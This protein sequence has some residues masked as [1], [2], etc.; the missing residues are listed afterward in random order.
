MPAQSLDQ[1]EPVPGPQPA[2]DAIADMAAALHA[3]AFPSNR[4]MEQRAKI[5]DAA[6]E[7]AAAHGFEAVGMRQLAAR[8]N[9]SAPGLYAHFDSK[10]SIIAAAMQHALSRF[11]EAV[12][13]PL[14]QQPSQ[15]HL[16]GLITRHVCFQLENLPLTK[17]NDQLLDSAAMRRFLPPGEHDLLGAAQRAYYDLLC[18]VIRAEAPRAPTDHVRLTAF[19]VLAMCDRVT[20][21]YKPNRTLLPDQVAQHY[22]RLAANLVASLEGAS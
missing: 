20:T 16:A 17:A 5:L 1:L 19:A 10:E 11:L 18:G 15:L 22:T 14:G 21:W 3:A 8:V 2:L 6:I 12:A 13:L 7:L 4:R 9:L